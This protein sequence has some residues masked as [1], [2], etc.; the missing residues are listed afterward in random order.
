MFS[1]PSC[2]SGSILVAILAIAPLVLPATLLLNLQ[3][4]VSTIEASAKSV[5]A[6]PVYGHDSQ[7]TGRTD[8]AG[9]AGSLRLEWTVGTS[10]S[11]QTGDTP[12][13][14]DSRGTIYVGSDYGLV[15]IDPS[16]GLNTTV[17]HHPG[18]S[19]TSVAVLSDGTIIAGANYLVGFSGEYGSVF[20]FKHDGTQMWNRTLTKNIY[21][22]IAI[23]S[24]DMIYVSDFHGPFYAI[25]PSGA[26]QWMKIG[27]GSYGG[28]AVARDSTIYAATENNLT[29]YRSDGQAY[30]TV[31]VWVDAQLVVEDSGAV[32]AIGYLCDLTPGYCS[33][34]SAR[35]L[36]ALNSSNGSV[37]WSSSSPYPDY[38]PS[39]GW[40]GTIYMV[41]GGD[42]KTSS[43][44][45]D[46][47]V[48]WTIQLDTTWRTTSVVDSNNVL[49]VHSKEGIV[50]VGPD[51]KVKWNFADPGYPIALAS[52]GTLY[53]YSSRGI[54]AL[55][56]P[57][58]SVTA[59]PASIGAQIGTAV[60]STLTVD[61]VNGFVGS[62]DLT[63]SSSPASGLFCVLSLASVT[64]GASQ[65]STMSCTGT[66]VG[67][68]IVIVQ[69]TSGKMSRTAQVRVEVS[70][71]TVSS[72]SILG[73]YPEMFYTVVGAIAAVIV[74]VIGTLAILKRRK[75][76]RV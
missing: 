24:D 46:G 72:S 25:R 5:N 23:G 3:R 56:G 21:A 55:I 11:D 2:C 48:K 26:L 8:V 33:L 53:Y 9:P 1:R 54:A 49:Y 15:A 52:D 71:R 43:I 18:W 68:Y 61:P 17:W 16:T 58:Y 62:I 57:D 70:P 73:L 6:W 28:V 14:I 4:N 35:S 66:V 42:N 69:G 38:H 13:V 60:K 65:T 45:P 29:A 10:P 44:N 34:T 36:F 27:S 76:I 37:Q 40:D 50:A 47:I 75:N 59:N 51:G 32:L 67:A 74:V 7:R 30:W 12:V 41:Y 31:P 20:A 19:V 22:Q 63:A 64:L 39:L